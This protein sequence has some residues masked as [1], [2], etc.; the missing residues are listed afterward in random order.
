MLQFCYRNSKSATKYTFGF[1][2]TTTDPYENF[3]YHYL[4]IWS[5]KK[6]FD[7][8]ENKVDFHKRKNH[9]QGIT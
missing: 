2:V 3:T 6:K 1:F 7:L 5:F 8:K 4:T 9:S